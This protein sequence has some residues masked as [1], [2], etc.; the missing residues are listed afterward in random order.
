MSKEETI[1]KIC[2]PYQNSD[3][4]EEKE[5]GS[6]ALNVSSQIHPLTRNVI[7]ALEEPESGQEATVNCLPGGRF[8]GRCYPLQ[9][10]VPS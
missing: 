4:G 7:Q 2:P 9:N 1:S 10:L 8:L 3:S 6:G 5:R